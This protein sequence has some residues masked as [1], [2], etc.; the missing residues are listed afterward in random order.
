MAATGDKLL[1]G[2]IVERL[3]R[4]LARLPKEDLHFLLQGVEDGIVDLQELARTARQQLADGPRFGFQRRI[5]DEAKQAPPGADGGD[6]E[7][8]GR[9]EA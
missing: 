7:T 1:K 4:Q 3:A 6:D 5:L 2:D 9:D 8:N